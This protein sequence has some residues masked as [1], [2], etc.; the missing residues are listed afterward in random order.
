MPFLRAFL[1]SLLIILE[2]N[3]HIP[4]LLARS[5]RIL[6]PLTNTFIASYRVK[7]KVLCLTHLKKRKRTGVPIVVQ[8]K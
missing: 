2:I 4:F 5:Y 8:W 7:A 1:Y 3:K 6:R